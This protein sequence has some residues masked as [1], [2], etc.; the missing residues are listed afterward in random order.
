MI[1]KRSETSYRLMCRFIKEVK[2]I[3]I[4]DWFMGLFGANKTLSI[5][6]YCGKIAAEIWYKELAVQSCINLIANTITKGEFLTFEKG[7]EVKKANYYLLNVEPNQNTSASSFWR[8]VVCNLIYNNECLVIQQGGMFY[9]ADSFEKVEF[10]FKENIYKN[11]SVAGFKLDSVY[12]ER[13][14]FHFKLHD[15]RI[16]TVIDGLYETYAKLIHS[17]GLN[18][19]R[20]NSKRGTLEIPTSY[21]QTEKG[22]KEIE[23]LLSSRFKRFFEAEGGAVLP[24]TSSLKYTELSSPTATNNDSGRDIRAFIDDV[25]DFVAIA[26]QVPPQLIKGTVADTKQ[27]VDNLLTFCINPIAEL[28]TDEINRKL[29]GEKH[30]LDRTYV[31]LDTTRIKAVD[32]KNIANPLDVLFRIGANTINDNLRILGRE[33]IDEDWANE[34]FITKNYDSVKNLKGGE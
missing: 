13:Q 16:S 12:N 2:V 23:E 25:F 33:T 29:Y 26:F 8:D 1:W 32:I 31:K 18:Y 17:S 15:E 6:G 9:V 30:Y 21:A 7:R 10:A 27:A 28:I 4:L 34:R 11:I 22:Q 14:V 3:A 5:S 24:L 20:N 19:K